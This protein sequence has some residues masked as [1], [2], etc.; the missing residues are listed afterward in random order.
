MPI[1]TSKITRPS[2]IIFRYCSIHPQGWVPIETYG[3]WASI[4]SS[5]NSSIHPQ[6]WVPIETYEY[7]NL[8]HRMAQVAFTPKGGCPLKLRPRF[9]PAQ[10]VFGSIHPQGWVPIETCFRGVVAFAVDIAV[11]FTPKG[12]CPLKRTGYDGCRAEHPTRVA[13]TP[14]GGCPLKRDTQGVHDTLDC[15]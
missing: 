15:W 9:V 4:R 13:F 10:E 12:G 7:G 1:E 3:P 14:K 5:R 6:G 8:K 2:L 11:A